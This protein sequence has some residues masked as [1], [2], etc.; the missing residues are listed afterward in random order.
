MEIQ[1]LIGGEIPAVFAEYTRGDADCSAELVN[2]IALT[3]KP[4]LDG[5][6]RNT[7]RCIAQQFFA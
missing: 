1:R 6:S 7:F 2:K 5:N 3:G 4:D